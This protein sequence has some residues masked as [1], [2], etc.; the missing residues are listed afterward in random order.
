MVSF[1]SQ[2]VY[3][4]F[5][6]LFSILQNY[7]FYWKDDDDSCLACV[8][9]SLETQMATFS[10]SFLTLLYNAE[11]SPSKITP[12]IY[13]SIHSSLF[14]HPF[15]YLLFTSPYPSGCY[16]CCSWVMSIIVVQITRRNT[17]TIQQG[18]ERGR[19]KKEGCC[20][21]C[22]FQYIDSATHTHTYSHISSNA[23]TSHTFCLFLALSLSAFCCYICVIS[24]SWY[25]SSMDDDEKKS[26][27]KMLMDACSVKP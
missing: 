25:P 4:G 7:F 22:L 14:A 8:R 1:P 21:C 9:Q 19:V 10:C 27:A 3:V 15:P 11:M 6:A 23:C 20:C 18:R 5:F 17:Y 24:T 2:H 12:S 16:C 26:E 13:P